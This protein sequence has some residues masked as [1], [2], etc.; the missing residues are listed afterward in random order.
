MEKLIRSSMLAG[1]AFLALGSAAS[2]VTFSVID[3]STNGVGNSADLF[4]GGYG[5]YTPQGATWAGENPR[6]TVPPS[7]V[8]RAYLSPFENTAL[9]G[10][11]D[12][13]AVGGQDGENGAPSPQTLNFAGDGVGSIRMLW[14]SIDNYNKIVFNGTETVTGDDVM[15]VINDD[16]DEPIEPF[17]AGTYNTVALI[18]FFAE[19][20]IT[21]MAFFSEQDIDA[22][23]EDK[24]AIEF[25]FAPVPLPAAGLMLLA[26]LGALAALRRRPA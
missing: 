20:A 2:A 13:F 12:F 14:G 21:S 16:L 9:S 26:G 1:A 4:A 15:A 18:E 11:R 23:G 8:R 22:P 6:V 24:A 3:W 5:A 19:D 17:G 25:A 10:S 7:Q